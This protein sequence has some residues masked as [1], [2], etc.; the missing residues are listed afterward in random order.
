MQYDALDDF[1]QRQLGCTGD[2][3]DGKARGDEPVVEEIGGRVGAALHSS[4]TS[5]AVQVQ[6]FHYWPPLLCTGAR[7]VY[8]P[9]LLNPNLRLH[10][11]SNSRQPPVQL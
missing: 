7:Y 1:T 11:Q 4:T 8:T 6:I 10:T 3:A 5:S 2:D 9:S